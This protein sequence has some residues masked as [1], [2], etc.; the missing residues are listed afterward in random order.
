M[1]L[2]IVYAQSHALQFDQ[3][4]DFKEVLKLNSIPKPQIETDAQILVKVTAASIN[5][6]DLNTI[7]GNYYV[8]YLRKVFTHLHFI[9]GTYGIKAK[10]FPGMNTFFFFFYCCYYMFGLY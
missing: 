7:A 6:S 8:Q 3:F 10:N 4:G 5:P 9:L 1:K 2:I